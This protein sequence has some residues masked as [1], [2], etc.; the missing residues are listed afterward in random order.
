MISQGRVGPQSCE[1]KEKRKAVS[2]FL[3]RNF[4]WSGFPNPRKPFMGIRKSPAAPFQIEKSERAFPEVDGT[5]LLLDNTTS[6]IRKFRLRCGKM[7]SAF[8]AVSYH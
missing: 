3:I 7:L 4:V 8:T 5:G 2:D 6:L 1:L